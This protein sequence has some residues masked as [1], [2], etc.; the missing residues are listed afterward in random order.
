NMI[1]KASHTTKNNASKAALS[2]IQVLPWL[3]GVLVVLAL[4]VMVALHAGRSTVVGE[5]I[6][7]GIHFIE[8]SKL[9]EVIL[10]PEGIHPDSLNYKS[11]IQALQE[12]PYV[13]QARI[14]VEPDGTI[15]IHIR[16]RQ[17]VA[18]LAGGEQKL[19]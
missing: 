7:E 11:L 3:T 12:V 1:N 15:R 18:L 10:I 13:E 2:F 17:P 19:Y 9:Q 4:A 5:V 16:E 6:F 8:E 14:G